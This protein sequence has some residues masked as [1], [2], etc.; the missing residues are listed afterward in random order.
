MVIFLTFQNI[1]KLEASIETIKLRTEQIKH[2]Q[3]YILNSIISTECDNIQY[4]TL[5]EIASINQGKLLIKNNMIDG[6]Y[7]V[8]GGGKIIGTHNI[9]NRD[10]DDVIITRV[11]D[12]NI[13]YIRNA[14]YLTDNAFALKTLNNT[15]ITKYLYYSI[16]SNKENLKD[17]YIG[18]AQK[19]ISKTNLSIVK[20]P[21]PSIEK[22]KEII[23]ILDGINNR[24]NED[25]K[26][27]EVLRK[28]ISK[29]I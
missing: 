5:G 7:N 12:I 13:N 8:I 14:Y 18:T 21:I 25:I 26:Y 23:D 2:E 24:I 22:Q 4:K 9:K 20:I 16:L 29:S 3:N 19:V 17:L 28:L 1:D 10:G 11:G 27:I 6:I 15:I